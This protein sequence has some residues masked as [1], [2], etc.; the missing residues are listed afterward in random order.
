MEILFAG[1]PCT[2]CGKTFR[3]AKCLQRHQLTHEEARDMYLCPEEGC[4]RG[5]FDLRNLYAHQRNYHGGSRFK[6]DDSTCGRTFATKVR[7]S[8]YYSVRFGKVCEQNASKTRLTR[9]FAQRI[10]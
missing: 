6:C 3:S 7:Y 5:Y 9:V 8:P 2:T 10:V 1:A 4:E